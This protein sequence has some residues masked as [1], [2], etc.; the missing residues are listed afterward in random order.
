MSLRTRKVGGKLRRRK[1]AAV[2]AE[3][4]TYA[5]F[6]TFHFNFF[7]VFSMFLSNLKFQFSICCEM[8]SMETINQYNE[9]EQLRAAR[10]AARGGGFREGSDDETPEP[11]PSKPLVRHS[12][13][14]KYV[15]IYV[16]MLCESVE[17]VIT[18]CMSSI[19]VLT[20]S[21]FPDNFV[22]LRFSSSNFFLLQ[23]NPHSSYTKIV[24]E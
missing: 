17:F 11:T 14:R 12:I 23:I 13:F 2:T 4:P 3:L 8:G 24:K 21:L 15:V 6:S 18:L 22:H 10:T 16:R 1:S 5:T 9:Q 20:D 19:L 7:H